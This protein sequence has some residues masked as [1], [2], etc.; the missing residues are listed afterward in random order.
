MLYAIFSDVHANL[1][2]FEAVLKDARRERA[3][4]FISL[5]DIVGYGPNP[6]ECIELTHKFACLSLAGNHDWIVL[7]LKEIDYLNPYAQQALL[8]SRENL[9]PDRLDYLQSL[10]LFAQIDNLYLVHAS[11][12]QPA[13]WHYI[14]SLEDAKLNFK[15][16]K[17][18][19]CL[20][21]HSHVPKIMVEAGT[22][23]WIH[24]GSEI[25]I[26]GGKRYIINVGSVGQPRD[27]NRKACYALYNAV[28][29]RFQLRRVSYDLVT[30]QE[31]MLLAG[32]PHRLA[33]RLAVGQ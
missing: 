11:P 26:E 8:W 5:G 15:H 6:N 33:D 22:T 25:T 7:N 31:K 2:A 17:G 3:D 4:R 16:F 14:R 18:Q 19:I 9:T 13:N 20:V 23:H 28:N 27:G 29:N 12:E 32:L 24:A 10:P 21:G 30:T 1:E